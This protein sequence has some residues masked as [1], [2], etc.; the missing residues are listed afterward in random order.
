MPPTESG[1]SHASEPRRQVFSATSRRRAR[2]TDTFLLTA[3]FVLMG[4]AAVIAFGVMRAP[5]MKAPDR[6]AS[7]PPGVPAN[8]KNAFPPSR[9]R[10]ISPT[11][12]RSDPVGA[13]KRM[14][15]GFVGLEEGG[16]VS[17]AEHARDLD[18]VIPRWAALTSGPKGSAVRVYRDQ[19]QAIARIRQSASEVA[20]YPEIENDIGGREMMALLA[21]AAARSALAGQVADYL[22]NPAL[23]GVVMNVTAMPE[24]ACGGMAAMLRELT[25]GQRER[26]KKIFAVVA[27]D[28]DPACL[29][30]I[31]DAVNYVVAAT[32]DETVERRRPGAL[33]SQGWFEATASALAASVPPS[34]LILTL[35]SF[36]SD[37]SW[38]GDWTIISVQRAWDIFKREGARLDFDPVSLNPSFGYAAADGGRHRVWLLDGATAFNQARAAMAIPVAGIAVWRLGLEDPAVWNVV[39][40]GH[41]PDQDALRALEQMPP[42][43]G[44]YRFVKAALLSIG[45]DIPGRRELRYDQHYGLVVGERIVSPASRGELGLWRPKDSDTV[46][47]TFD[48]GPDPRFTGRILDVLKEKGVH[49]TFYLIGR[50]VLSSP[51]LVRRIYAEGHD[52]GSHTFSHPDAFSIGLGRLEMEMNSTQ[53]IL[54]AVTG[55]QTGLFRP[56]YASPHAGYMDAGPQVIQ[57][58]TRLGYLTA[59]MDVDSC[60]FCDLGTEWIVD[61]VVH[62]V[63]EGHG[64]IV[65]MHDSGGDREATVAALPRVIDGVRA[66]GFRFVSTHELVGLPREAVMHPW[67]PLAAVTDVQTEVWRRLI[68]GT[69]WS[70]ERWPALMIGTAI[71]GVARL[72]LVVV[73]AVFQSWRGARRRRRL[74]EPYRGTIEVIVPA[75]NEEKVVCRT[76]ESLLS[77]IGAVPNVLVVDDGSKDRTSDVLRERFAGE[78]RLTVL[79]K[80]NGGKAAALNYGISRSTADV[81]VAIDGDTIL[82]LEAIDRLTRPFVDPRVGAVAG[83]VVVGNALNLM[84][85]FQ[86]LEYVMSQ[87]LDRRAFELFNAIGVVP[88]AIGAWRR[89]AVLEAGGYARDTLAEDADLTFAVQMCGWRVL[90]EPSAVAMTEA[91]ETLRAFMKQRFRWM[92]GTLQVACKNLGALLRR[93]RGLTFIAIPNVFLFQMVFTLL[94]PIVDAMLLWSIVGGFYF[95][96][97]DQ[98]ESLLLIGRYWLVFQTAECLAAVVAIALS[99]PD[100]ARYWRLVPLLLLQRFTYRQLLYVTAIRS[101]LAAVKGTLVGWGKLVRTGNVFAI[102]RRSPAA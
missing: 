61:S 64:R 17:L 46:A 89:Q 24:G 81:I 18:G 53:R 30:A 48:D 77:A 36:A 42:G 84:T 83:S 47:L 31:A 68:A 59:G 86:A 19:P 54:E 9:E 1:Q 56:P 97:S 11:K 66:A 33:A 2:I 41:E 58:A 73:L 91:P 7:D 39:G 40:R 14:R 29:R 87:N 26:G 76:V 3:A 44:N 85:R 45:P 6:P 99:G 94:A 49:A 90:N 55:V 74:R 12:D 67:H 20:I 95:G 16:L 78:P 5:S 4:F 22:S 25:D 50:N 98:I 75:Y 15:L 69:Q 57:T 102:N 28:A 65:V 62:G 70:G 101:L 51:E 23:S 21:D 80:E 88:G 79:R 82:D 93:P 72:T 52:V 100:R 71:L 35:G 27:P 37:V 38:T 10:P 34:K 60:D 63:I 13:E 32:Q 92:F 8:A 96:N 43:Y